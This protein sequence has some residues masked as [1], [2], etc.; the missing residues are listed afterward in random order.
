VTKLILQWVG[1]SVDRYLN[2][3]MRFDDKE[4]KLERVIAF[5]DVPERRSLINHKP[6]H[7]SKDNLLCD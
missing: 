4:L 1:D 7:H 5:T 3:K 6:N 2:E